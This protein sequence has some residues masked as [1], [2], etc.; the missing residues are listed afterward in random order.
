MDERHIEQKPSERLC[1]SCQSPLVRTPKA[2]TTR[3]VERLDNGLMVKALERL[4]DAPELHRERHDKYNAE[5]EKS[6]EEKIE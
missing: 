2:P 6:L 1:K 3:V 4:A 5:R